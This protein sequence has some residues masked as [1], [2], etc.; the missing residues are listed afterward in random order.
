MKSFWQEKEKVENEKIGMNMFGKWEKSITNTETLSY[1]KTKLM[2]FGE[3]RIA[4]NVFYHLTDLRIRLKSLYYGRRHHMVDLWSLQN[5][6]GKR[7]LNCLAL[8]SLCDFC[9][10]LFFFF[11]C[12][13][14]H[15]L[16]YVS[17]RV[18]EN[19]VSL[20]D[21]WEPLI[22]PINAKVSSFYFLNTN[23]HVFCTRMSFDLCRNCVNVKIQK[24]QG[25]T[26]PRKRYEVFVCSIRYATQC[27]A[28]RKWKIFIICSRKGEVV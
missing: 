13:I 27:M 16:L 6:T 23:T 10:I 15:L 12:I 11:F 2:V 14:N 9:M 26:N 18:W 20:Q 4:S 25:A 1:Q 24:E 21:S 22:K 3:E 28:Y 5:A 7:A 17:L 19:L 8:N